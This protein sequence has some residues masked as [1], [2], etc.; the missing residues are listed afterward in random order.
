VRERESRDVGVGTVFGTKTQR[1]RARSL[2]R[3][4][5]RR[6]PADPLTHPAP[7]PPRPSPLFVTWDAACPAGGPPRLRGCIG[8]LEPRPLRAGLRD[9]ALTSALRDRRFSPISPPELP[10]LHCTVSLL[11]AFERVDA[12]DDWTVGTHGLTIEFEDPASGRARGATYLP[13]V[14]REQG[15]DRVTTLDSLMRKAGYGGP[16]SPAL[17]R[18]VAVTRYEA[19][20]AS[21][22]AAAVFG[23]GTEK[24]QKGRGVNGRVV[25]DGEEDGEDGGGGLRDGL[26]GGRG[27]AW[28]FA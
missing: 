6:D 3:A 24:K 7:T 11:R 8:T 27:R 15:W 17:R 20:T 1:R 22:D 25:V 9:Y 10:S 23:G 26:V 16:I 4:R 28:G 5:T 14:A 2:A 21:A 18:E 12:W 19:S 13:A